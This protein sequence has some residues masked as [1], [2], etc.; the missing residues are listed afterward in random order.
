MRAKYLLSIA[1]LAAIGLGLGGCGWMFAPRITAVLSASPTSIE[2]GESV[3][4]T[5]SG[6]TGNITSYTLEFGDSSTPATGSDVDTT[7][8]HTYDEAN[9]YIAQLTVQD[10]R[11]RTDTDTVTITVTDP[12][13]PTASLGVEPAEG[14]APLEV[15]FTVE[16]T[17]PTGKKIV[18]W[19][20]NYGDGEDPAGEVVE[21]SSI[22]EE[23][24][25][26]YDEAG[27]YIAELLVED[28]DGTT[29]SD[30]VTV[31]VTPPGPEIT[32]FTAVPQTPS[33]G[34]DVTF[35]FEAEANGDQ[36]LVKWELDSGD[37]YVVSTTL[38]TP[39]DT[40][41]VTHTYEDGYEQT[42]SYTASV[43]VWDDVDATDS[44]TLEIEVE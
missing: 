40:L 16:A 25:Y 29:A 10:D 31:T 35:E 2:K 32:S 9:I 11:G 39:T 1:V 43:Q 38:G 15:T 6:S 8:V 17:A 13:A 12:D 4:F 27:E 33:V 5:L 36:E 26:T 3:E 37:G 23:L 34:V 24:D 22:S 41:N 21:V 7:V 28:E 14:T 44:E 42:G 30:T 19:T 20:L 18:E